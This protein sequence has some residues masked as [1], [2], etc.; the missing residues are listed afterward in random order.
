M[1]PGEFS[2]SHSE[3]GGVGTIVISGELDMETSP[4]LHRALA[5]FGAMDRLIIDTTNLAFIDSTGLRALLKC[6]SKVG[7]DRF[8]LV[9]GPATIRLL[10]IAGMRNVFGLGDASEQAEGPLSFSA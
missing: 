5:D 8:E 2:I 7:S 1:Q 3:E 10:E 6:R 4:R 9:A